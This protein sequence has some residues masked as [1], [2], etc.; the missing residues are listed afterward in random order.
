MH[1]NTV[2]IFPDSVYVSSYS[3]EHITLT[4]KLW[5][6][7][8]RL[9]TALLCEAQLRLL[10]FCLIGTSGSSLTFGLQSLAYRRMVDSLSLFFHYYFGPCFSEF[11]SSAPMPLTSPHLVLRLL[12]ILT[13]FYHFFLNYEAVGAD[14]PIHL[15][16]PF[17]L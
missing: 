13:S 12:T 17:A 14:L 2:K 11:A 7:S 10:F 3:M 15:Q 5:F 1:P 4:N 9:T 6:V 16:S 8:Q